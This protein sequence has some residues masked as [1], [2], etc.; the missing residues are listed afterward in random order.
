MVIKYKY[1]LSSPAGQPTVDPQDP[2]IPPQALTSH[3]KDQGEHYLGPHP[4]DHCLQMHVVTLDMLQVSSGNIIGAHVKI[5][6][7]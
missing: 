2:S 1:R 6:K 7:E 3:W 4:L 5:R